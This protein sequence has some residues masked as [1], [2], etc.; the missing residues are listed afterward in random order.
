MSGE[1][2]KSAATGVSPRP[3]PIL[4]FHHLDDELDD[5]TSYAKGA[6]TDL[7]SALAERFRFVTLADALRAGNAADAAEDAGRP[8]LVLTFDDAYQ[9]ILT[10]ALAEVARAGAIGTVF[11]ITGYT[12]RHNEW[13]RKCAYWR[14]HLDVAGLRELRDAG[15]EIGSHTVEHQ[16]L[17]RLPP[18]L[19]TSELRDSRAELEDLLGTAVTSCSY[20]Y[21]FNDALVREEAG[22]YYE[23]AVTTTTKPGG[24]DPV[25]HRLALRRFMVTRSMSSSDVAKGIDEFWGEP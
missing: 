20:P 11:A 15:F 4:G 10:P 22:R 8:P 9:S 17:T 21:G 24:I 14:P 19:L 16:N 5:Y 7:V 23:Q 2:Q 6:Y 13:N 1:A 18:A 25:A 3:V 12:G